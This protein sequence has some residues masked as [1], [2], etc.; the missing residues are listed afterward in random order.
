[1]GIKTTIENIELYILVFRSFEIIIFH[2][3]IFISQIIRVAFNV[4]VKID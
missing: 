1:M 4:D 3:L 2:K